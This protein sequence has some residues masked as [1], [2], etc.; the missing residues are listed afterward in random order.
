MEALIGIVVFVV[1]GL[2]AWALAGGDPSRYTAREL[3][4]K[5]VGIG[6]IVGKSLTEIESVVGKPNSISAV[7]NGQILCQWVVPGYHVGLLFENDICVGIS[8]ESAV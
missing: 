1:I 3:S 2:I 7:G 5:F 8:H 6:V 4:K